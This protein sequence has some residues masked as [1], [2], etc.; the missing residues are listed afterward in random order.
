MA[1]YETPLMQQFAAIKAEYS[2][3][4]ILFRLGDF[5]ELFAEDAQVGT[6]VLG[7]TLTRKAQ[8]KGGDVPMSGIPYHSL[9]THLPKLISAGYKVALVEQMEPADGKTLVKRDVVRIITPGTVLAE[10]VLSNQSQRYCAAFIRTETACAFAFS[11]LSTGDIHF[12]EHTGEED[13]QKL[14]FEQEVQRFL[15]VEILLS[16]PKVLPDSWQKILKETN[17]ILT[18]FGAWEE[19]ERTAETKLLEHLS[20]ATLEPFQLQQRPLAQSVVSQ[21]IGYAQ[22]TQRQNVPHLRQIKEYLPESGLLLDPATQRNLELFTSL[23]HGDKRGTLIQH[24]D[25]TATA[26]GSRTVQLWLQQ[27]ST[28]LSLLQERHAA[29][30]ELFGKPSLLTTLRQKLKQIGDIERLLSR[31]TLGLGTPKDV[32]RLGVSLESTQNLAASI[33]DC[34]SPVFAQLKPALEKTRSIERTI[35]STIDPETPNDPAQGGVIRLG[36]NPELDSWRKKLTTQHDWMT[37]YEQ[38]LRQDT[39]ISTLKVRNNKVFGFYIEVSRGA[40]HKVP[41]TFERK[42]TLVNGERY[43]TSELKQQEVMLLEAKEK[44]FATEIEMLAALIEKIRQNIPYLQTVAKLIGTID[45]LSTFAQTARDRNYVQPTLH[46]GTALEIEQGRHPV[47]E[48]LLTSGDFIPND[49]EL[50]TFGQHPAIFLLTGP[51]MGGKSVYLRQTA[52]ITLLAHIGSFVPATSARI[53]LTDRIF[54]RSGAADNIADGLS[55]FMV[56]MVETATILRHAT[57]KSL[58]LLDEVGRGTSTYDGLSLAWAILEFLA[59]KKQGVPKTIF[60]THYLELQALSQTY[61]CIENRQVGVHQEADTVAFLHQILPGGAAHSFGVNVAKMAGVPQT[62]TKRAQELLA[63][64]EAEQK[65]QVLT[66]KKQ[67]V[68]DEIQHMQIESVTPTQAL[69]LIETWKNTLQE[70]S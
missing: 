2:D 61:S 46:T 7:L 52:L 60:A 65:S 40:S 8:S 23:R 59:E 42:Q 55:T 25:T 22:Y 67:T 33:Q 1:T 15:P 47:V 38:Q 63:S 45:V 41:S 31:I 29:V 20:V 51:N 70:E 5:Y 32:Y 69:M 34:H 6:D 19:W 54:V 43:S 3:C 12:S 66:Q 21:L 9:D 35:L 10:S 56:E 16:S 37:Q 39:G 48:S 57:A 49:T 50:D 30:A 13:S 11:D 68:L 64:F 53:P 26:L 44:I 27:P 17:S 28:D 14:W 4:L 18:T 58:I 62:V 36:V 24:L